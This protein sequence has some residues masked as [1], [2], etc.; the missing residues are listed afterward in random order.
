MKSRLWAVVVI[1]VVAAAAQEPK[2]SGAAATPAQSAPAKAAPAP[3]ARPATLPA[4]TPQAGGPAGVPLDAAVITIEG[5]CEHPPAAAG[6]EKPAGAAEPAKAAP[7]ARGASAAAAGAHTAPA[8]SK[9]E[10]AKA[11]E[12][13]PGPCQR[14][15]TRAEFEKVANALNPQMS[16]PVRRRLADFYASMLIAQAKVDQQGLLST[17]ESQQLLHFYYLQGLTTILNAK[18]SDDA[19]NVPQADIEKYYNEHAAD[20]EEATVERVLIPRSGPP[21]KPEHVTTKEN[22]ENLR[23]RA[24]GGEDFEKLQKDA[25][26]AAG[27]EVTPPTKLTNLRRQ[28]LP[29]AQSGQVF[30]LQPGQISEV[31]EEP[32][33]FFLYKMDSKRTIPLAEAQATIRS[34]L[35]NKRLQEAAQ[36]IQKEFKAT[37]NDSYFPAPA[38]P[39]APPPTGP[40][41]EGP[42]GEGGIRPAPQPAPPQSKPAPQPAPPPPHQ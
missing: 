31:I 11:E 42:A 23:T 1:C 30:A 6:A 18:L 26:T 40:R 38:P 12:P 9:P 4:A 29:A 27:E 28:S 15:V 10:T 8:G 36:A 13:V 22:A 39:P 7:H 41:L 17:P 19:T 33:A 14:V 35:A 24:V 20:F 25:S 34:V 16:A 3:E 32:N 21:G 5:I 2:P 37:L